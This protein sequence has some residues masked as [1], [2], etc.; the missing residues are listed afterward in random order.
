MDFTLSL[1]PLDKFGF[2]IGKHEG[3]ALGIIHERRFNRL[4]I[5]VPFVGMLI[6]DH[7]NMP[8]YL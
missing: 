5:Q 2:A 1:N 4:S 3:E 8:R 7:S 6:I